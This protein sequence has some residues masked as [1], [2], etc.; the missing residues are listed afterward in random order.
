MSQEATSPLPGNRWSGSYSVP[1][2]TKDCHTGGSFPL[3]V[4]A[5]ERGFS[6]SFISRSECCSCLSH[7]PHELWDP[8]HCPSVCFQFLLE[9]LLAQQQFS[10]DSSWIRWRMQGGWRHPPSNLVP[11]ILHPSPSLLHEPCSV[12]WRWTCIVG[13]REAFCW[14]QPTSGWAGVRSEEEGDVQV[15]FPAHAVIMESWYLSANFIAHVSESTS[16]SS[17]SFCTLV[18]ASTH[19]LWTWG[20][21]S[22][23]ASSAL[24]PRALYFPLSFPTTS[25]PLLSFLKWS[26]FC[27]DLDWYVQYFTE[28]LCHKHHCYCSVTKSC[29]AVCDPMGCSTSG[30]SVLH[31]VLE[32][33]QIHVHWVHDAIWPAHPLLP[34]SPLVSTFY[35]LFY[36][37]FLS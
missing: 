27:Q 35:F 16:P 23:T 31:Y 34:S 17:L 18:T 21:G 29:P 14:V 28:L 19:S 36:Y 5:V 12:P 30:F 24:S 37:V 2:A 20:R 7:Q 15:G 22:I 25:T 32:F 13:Y 26:N 33:T 4:Q 1:P 3:P 11:R 10:E 8:T 9:L 6:L